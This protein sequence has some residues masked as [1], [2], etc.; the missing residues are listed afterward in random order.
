M[1][2]W[3]YDKADWAVGALLVAAMLVAVFA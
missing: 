3:V 2:G 1:I